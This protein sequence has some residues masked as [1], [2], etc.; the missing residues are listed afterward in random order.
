[1]AGT[2]AAWDAVGAPES[3][4]DRV[5]AA[6]VWVLGWKAGIRG[7]TGVGAGARGEAT[8]ANDVRRRSQFASAM[9][10]SDR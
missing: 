9:G 5:S 7:E 4:I 6:K 10:E 3:K 8:L 1:M 2:G